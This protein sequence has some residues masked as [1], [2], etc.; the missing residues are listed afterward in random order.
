MRRFVK[1]IYTFTVVAAN[2]L[3]PLFLIDSWIGMIWYKN[4][5]W[6]RATFSILIW[7]AI[8]ETVMNL[9]L[10]C[11]LGY[12]VSRFVERKEQQPFDD[13]FKEP[14][15]PRSEF[16]KSKPC[17]RC[18]AMGD[19]ESFKGSPSYPN[20]YRK[21][22]NLC[23]DCRKAQIDFLEERF[24]LETEGLL[25]FGRS[26]VIKDAEEVFGDQ[27]ID[28][29]ALL[30]VAEKD[31]DAARRIL[32]EDSFQDVEPWLEQNLKEQ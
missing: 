17:E 23:F 24:M 3:L 18:G 8:L 19:T 27:A 32:E 6:I 7:G 31:K 16:K 14:K 12:F 20:F 25:N 10:V 4:I 9:I 28:V 22:L 26:G 29:L 30:R 13:T 21:P 15:Q 2:I 5:G 1:G 11:G